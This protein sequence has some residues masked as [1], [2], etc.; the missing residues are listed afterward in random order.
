M[1]RG[2]RGAPQRRLPTLTKTDL[3]LL[4]GVVAA[5]LALFAAC[6]AF[7]RSERAADRLVSPSIKALAADHAADALT[8]GV[9]LL[10]AFGAAAANAVAAPE[11]AK[12]WST[13]ARLAD[14]WEASSS[15]SRCSWGGA[16]R[17]GTTSPS[18]SASEPRGRHER[19][20]GRRWRRGDARFF[21]RHFRSAPTTNAATTARVSNVL[22]RPLLR[23]KGIPY[24]TVSALRFRRGR[25]S[26]VPRWRARGGR[27]GGGDGAGDDPARVARRVPA[28]PAGPGKHGRGGARVRARRL[29]EARRPSTPGTRRERRKRESVIARGVVARRR[30]F[31]LCDSWEDGFPVTPV[32]ADGRHRARPGQSRVFPLQSATS[33]NRRPTI[34]GRSEDARRE[35]H[36]CPSQEGHRRLGSNVA[37]TCE[38]GEG[39]AFD[40]I[41]APLLPE[42]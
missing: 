23:P 30:D 2:S 10:A 26:R 3:F 37:L 21:R 7:T 39:P 13:P 25:D 27:G 5:K 22:L 40:T 8:N 17:P 15:P 6:V 9:A 12:R 42:R 24:R 20:F 18:W 28:A 32:A 4:F 1:C 38:E 31:F 34:G 36:V 41:G 33:P 29:R 19:R 16:C 11:K 14:P 35:R